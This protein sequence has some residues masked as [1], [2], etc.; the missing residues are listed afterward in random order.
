MTG[1]SSG[2]WPC[3][4]QC[5]LCCST[6]L[7]WVVAVGSSNQRIPPQ[8]FWRKRFFVVFFLVLLSHN[9]MSSFGTL[10]SQTTSLT[11]HLSHKQLVSQLTSLRV[12][13]LDGTHSMSLFGTR[14]MSLFGTRSVW[15]FGTQVSQVHVLVWHTLHVRACASLFAVLV[16]RPCLPHQPQ[17]P[18]CLQ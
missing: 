8:I 2:Q 15:L 9:S 4:A 1:V 12:S 14:S 7:C 5:L 13:Q 11:T 10:V 6:A 18:H 16:C 3:F 17:G